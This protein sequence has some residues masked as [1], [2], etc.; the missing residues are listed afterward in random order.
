MR[1]LILLGFTLLLADLIA[2]GRLSHYLAPRLHMLSYVT[3][4]ILA[5]LTAVSIRQ[6]V[7]G[8]DSYE[9][10]CEDVHKVPRSPLTSLVVYGLFALPLVMGLVLPDK[11]LGSAVAEKRGVT[12]L[13]GDGKWVQSVGS[14]AKPGSDQAVSPAPDTNAPADGTENTKAYGYGGQSKSDAPEKAGDGGKPKQS[15]AQTDE[16]IRQRFAANS[17]GD[18]YTDIA[19]SLYKQPVIQLNDKLFLDGLT[20]MELYAKEFAGKELETLGFVYRE[21]GFTP[22]QFVVAR[23]SVSCCTADATVFGILVEDKAARKWATDS[24][25]KVR[26]KLELRSVDGYDMLVLKASRIQPVKAPK[27]PYVYYNFNAAAQ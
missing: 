22:Q 13:T 11:T 27:D 1:S 17:F 3:V 16:Q 25:V 19:V 8:P 6:A 12:L 23:F 2:T 7:V 21:P 5:L 4:A 24:W 15:A 14:P 20:T 10:D 9:C 26:G 18:F